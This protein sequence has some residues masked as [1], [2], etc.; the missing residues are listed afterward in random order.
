M[1]VISIWQP[2]ASLAVH[3]FKFYETR[4]WPAPAS[5]IGQRIGIASTKNLKPEQR[6]A[7]ED[8]EFADFYADTKL[9]PL[10]ELPL[11]C[12]LG[13]VVV[14]GCE[15]ITEELVDQVTREEQLFGW[16]ELGRY[17][18]RLRDRE[19]YAEP[20][21]VRGKQGIWTFEEQPTNVISFASRMPAHGEG[22]F[23]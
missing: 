23:A 13:T 16:W 15:Q 9:P 14:D 3:G 7:V 22:F 4:G 8:E 11:G 1:K 20:I 12:L 2:F 6:A 17:A 18:W 10:D 19:L 21:P 5:L